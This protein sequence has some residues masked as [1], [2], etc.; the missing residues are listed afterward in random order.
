MQITSLKNC[1]STFNFFP[2]S[3]FPL[4]GAF[5]QKVEHKFVNMQ[6]AFD[7]LSK[8]VFKDHSKWGANKNE[9]K[10]GDNAHANFRF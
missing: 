6:I 9:H 10:E 5:R 7:I 1:I 2:V 8:L 3:V 4:F